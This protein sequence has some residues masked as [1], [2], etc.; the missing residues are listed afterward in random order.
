VYDRRGDNPFLARFSITDG[1][2]DGAEQSD[3]IEA[4][5]ADLG[6]GFPGGLLVVQNGVNDGGGN[7]TF[8]L[9][10]WAAVMGAAGLP[11][12]PACDPRSP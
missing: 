8:L 2:I 11:V 9:V 6:A 10:P 3:G 1:A 7:Q 5:A 4:T 12:A